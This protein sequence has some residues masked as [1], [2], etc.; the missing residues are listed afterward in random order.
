MSEMDTIE[1]LSGQPPD[2]SRFI[3]PTTPSHDITDIYPGG[4]PPV[5][6][7]PVGLLAPLETFR[8]TPAVRHCSE[9]ILKFLSIILHP[10]AFCVVPRVGSRRVKRLAHETSAV[11]IL[12]FTRVARFHLALR[13]ESLV[14][15]LLRSSH[16]AHILVRRSTAR[17]TGQSPWRIHVGSSHSECALR[18]PSCF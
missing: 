4:D 6:L 18:P 8:F 14:G 15:Y 1:P 2:A 12:C 17:V 10:T 5:N 9:N 7:Q 11:P 13:F 3:P 16:W